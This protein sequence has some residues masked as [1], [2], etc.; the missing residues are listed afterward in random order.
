[1]R[2]LKVARMTAD[3]AATEAIAPARMSEVIQYRAFEQ[4]R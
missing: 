3:L 2:V 1:M 4:D